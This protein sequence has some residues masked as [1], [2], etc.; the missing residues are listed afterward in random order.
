MFW[1]YVN[2]VLFLSL[3]PSENFIV[4][5]T[6][7]SVAIVRRYAYS[8]TIVQAAEMIE[9]ERAGVS[10]WVVFPLFSESLSMSRDC[11]PEAT[12]QHTTARSTNTAKMMEKTN[13]E[14]RTWHNE[15]VNV[16]KIRIVDELWNNPIYIPTQ[17]RYIY[18]GADGV[19]HILIK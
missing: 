5:W 14:H 6:G 16:I 2:F 1:N 13:L 4:K 15:R 8:N 3:S 17:P 10:A 7:V 19:C 18:L 9:I 12:I 11:N